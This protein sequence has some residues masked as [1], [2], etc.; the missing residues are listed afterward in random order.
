VGEPE[1][2]GVERDPPDGK[3][4]AGRL[5]VDRVPQNRVTEVGEVDADLVGPP[6]AELGLDERYRAEPLEW[7]QRRDGGAPAAPGRKRRPPG[8][9]PG[10]PNGAGHTPLAG[11]RPPHERDV[12]PLDAVSAEL[13]LQM[14][15]REVGEGEH[16][17]A[18]RLAVET[19]HDVDPPVAARPTFDLG[20][21]A[22]DDGVLL[23]GGRAVDEQPRRF[24]DDEDVRVDVEHLDRRHAWSGSAPG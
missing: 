20:A 4:I 15:R 2:L 9:G 18:G 16:K 13:P 10:P 23:G 6:G 1:C 5:A 21:R 11:Q 24:V 22:T 19:V 14:L 7:P 12:P 8:A 3:R 17:H